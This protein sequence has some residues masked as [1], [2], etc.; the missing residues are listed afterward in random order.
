MLA[1]EDGNQ[2]WDMLEEERQGL[3]TPLCRTPTSELLHLATTAPQPTHGVF[4]ADVPLTYT[5]PAPPPL[6]TNMVPPP[7]K[8]GSHSNPAGSCWP[9]FLQRPPLL[10]SD[11]PPQP[12]AAAAPLP[13]PTPP[14]LPP[15][16]APPTTTLSS[17]PHVEPTGLDDLPAASLQWKETLEGGWWNPTPQQLHNLA[18]MGLL[19][20]VPNSSQ[21]LSLNVAAATTVPSQQASSAPAFNS[22]QA[23]KSPRGGG[24]GDERGEGKVDAGSEVAAKPEPSSVA[25]QSVDT[26]APPVDAKTEPADAALSAVDPSIIHSSLRSAPSFP[27]IGPSQPMSFRFASRVF[28]GVGVA[29]SGAPRYQGPVVST[30]LAVAAEKSGLGKGRMSEMRYFASTHLSHCP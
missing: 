20:L 17:T 5:F 3:G 27:S 7:L 9:V 2:V 11:R 13:R 26:P 22:P 21:G 19:G 16:P 1:V 25:S 30:A 18:N 23:F 29:S 8:E 28:K 24:G 6:P 12:S 14:P 4:P 15:P 10:P